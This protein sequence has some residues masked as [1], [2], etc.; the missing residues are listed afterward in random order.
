V[1]AGLTALAIMC[2]SLWLVWRAGKVK[3]SEQTLGR[4]ETL[5]DVID[6]ARLL[7]EVR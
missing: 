1:A 3:V 4:A 5:A 6:D 2:R 7:G